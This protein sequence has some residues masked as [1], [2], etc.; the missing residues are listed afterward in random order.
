MVRRV[1]HFVPAGVPVMRISRA[2]RVSAERE[3]H[4][5]AALDVGPTRTMQQDVE[6]G[7]IQIVDIGLRAMSPAVNDPSTAISCVDQLSRI[8]IYWLGR[9]PPKAGYYA[10]PHVL[11]VVVPWMKFDRMIETAFD[12]IRHYAKADL[13]VSLRL[14]RAFQDIATVSQRRDEHALLAELARRVVAGCNR[15]LPSDELVRLKQ[16]AA[17]LEAHIRGLE[18]TAPNAP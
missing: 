13:A 3:L 5:L 11:R 8:I 14:I 18:V 1:G 12:Q 6:F 7:M 9:E 2:E 4:L 17:A 10:P 15:H 16:R